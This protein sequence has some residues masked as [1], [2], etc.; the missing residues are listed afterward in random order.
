VGIAG[1]EPTLFELVSGGQTELGAAALGAATGQ[2][3]RTRPARSLAAGAGRL[4]GALLPAGA[5]RAGGTDR[6]GW[7]DRW[8]A[9][10]GQL[11]AAVG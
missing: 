2:S 1:H 4:G 6:R 11:D 5:S 10:M 8:V 3:E 7:V 9:G